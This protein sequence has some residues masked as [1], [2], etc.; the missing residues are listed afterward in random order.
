VAAL[1][2]TEATLFAQLPTAADP[3]SVAQ[4]LQGVVLQRIREEATLR[5]SSAT[6]SAQ[7]AENERKLQ[8]EALRDQITGLERLR[9]LA[10]DIGQFTSSLRIS[11]LSPLSFEAQLSEARQLFERTLSGASA[12]NPQD[13]A[14]LTGNARAYLDEARSFFASSA[15]YAGVFTSVTSALE[16]LSGT[17]VDPQIAALQGQLDAIGQL[18][19]VTQETSAEEV[20]ALR[21]ID[22]ALAVRESANAEAINRQ[23]AI[24][25][26][27]IKVLRDEV[28]PELRAQ[29]V[30]A[31]ARH[32]E[33]TRLLDQI[34]ANTGDLVDEAELAGGAP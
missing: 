23:T 29:L 34:A 21:A 12:G 26:E 7:L 27:Q 22:E 10:A 15:D 33:V 25:Q 14:N 31:A 3:V 2:S 8:A 13:V 11:D 24:A 17:N 1:R 16:G 30:Q 20:A 18:S 32:A 5:E 19:Q 6:A 4:R 9:D 28:I